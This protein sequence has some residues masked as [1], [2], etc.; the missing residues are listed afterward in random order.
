MK[1]LIV[2]VVLAFVSVCFGADAVP[3]VVPIAAPST[4]TFNNVLAWIVNHQVII[5]GLLVGILDF[6][7]SINPQWKSNSVGHLIYLFAQKLTGTTVAETSTVVTTTPVVET[8]VTTIPA[9]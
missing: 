3:V 5:G 6:I 7:F 2:F 9:A 4:N 8:T 1:S